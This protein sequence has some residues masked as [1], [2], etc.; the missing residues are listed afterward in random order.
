MELDALKLDDEAKALFWWFMHATALTE[1]KLHVL[2]HLDGSVHA[3]EREL[4][5]LGG[6]R[7]SRPV[8][9]GNGAIEPTCA[10]TEN[11]R[12]ASVSSARS[13]RPSTRA[14]RRPEQTPPEPSVTKSWAP[15]Q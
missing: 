14:G 7:A 13:V 6:Y 11:V 4:T 5:S 8:R 15:C 9:I 10:S 12:P 3:K 1:P 2:Y